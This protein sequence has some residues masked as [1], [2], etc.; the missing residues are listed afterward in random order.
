MV[1]WYEQVLVKLL[2]MKDESFPQKK[3]ENILMMKRRG[4][5]PAGN[6][7]IGSSLVSRDQMKIIEGLSARATVVKR[8]RRCSSWPG[9]HN[10]LFHET[11]RSVLLSVHDTYQGQIDL[12]SVQYFFG[13]SICGDVYVFSQNNY[14]ND[15]Q[16]INKGQNQSCQYLFC[17]FEA[18]VSKLIC[19]FLSKMGKYLCFRSVEVDT[20]SNS[21]LILVSG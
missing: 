14:I 20:N 18:L 10:H 2:Q 1:Y 9:A 12:M 16:R 13:P 15:L 6:V 3:R 21:F 17:G 8:K 4:N 11:G 19:S 7:S 5:L